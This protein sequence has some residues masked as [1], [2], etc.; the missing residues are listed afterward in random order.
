[1]PAIIQLADAGDHHP[2]R[3]GAWARGG[4][5]LSGRANSISN[6]GHGGSSE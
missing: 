1:M 4:Y 5:L 6:S 3:D 2:A